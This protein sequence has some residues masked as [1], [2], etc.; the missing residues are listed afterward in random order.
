MRYIYGLV[1]PVIKKIRYIGVSDNPGKR[2]HQHIDDAGDSEKARWIQSVITIGLEPILMVLSEVDDVV[3][4]REEASWIRF[5]LREGWPLTNEMVLEAATLTRSSEQSAVFVGI[6][7]YEIPM[8]IR[9][10]FRPSVFGKMLGYK[11]E[12]PADVLEVSFNTADGA[13]FTL[14][15]EHIGIDDDGK[16]IYGN[17][18]L[19]VLWATQATIVR[20]VWAKVIG[21]R[22]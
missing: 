14:Y 9:E 4:L 6:A 8:F 7:Q 18:S 13:G 21:H 19:N 17:P 10:S 11:G 15:Y 12:V 3:S 2:Y 22:Q 1:C 5:G 16:S 20:L